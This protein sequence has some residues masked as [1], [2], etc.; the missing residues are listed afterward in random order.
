MKTLFKFFFVL[1]LL[2]VLAYAGNRAYGWYKVQR[3]LRARL[4]AAEET[5]KRQAYLTNEKRDKLD[6]LPQINGNPYDAEVHARWEAAKAKGALPEQN[7]SL[8]GQGSTGYAPNN[9]PRR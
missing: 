7:A 3:A 6:G 5:I 9:P 4:A 1:V 2:A 8:S